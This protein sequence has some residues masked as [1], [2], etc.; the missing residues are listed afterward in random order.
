MKLELEKMK[1]IQKPSEKK[2]QG[3]ETMSDDDHADDTKSV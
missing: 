1:Q 3:T 2:S